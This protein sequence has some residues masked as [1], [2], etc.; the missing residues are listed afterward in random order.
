MGGTTK[1]EMERL[2][3]EPDIV[4]K[5]RTRRERGAQVQSEGLHDDS[6]ALL[7]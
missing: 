3:D 5:A 6:I 2:K 1:E 7:A 4:T